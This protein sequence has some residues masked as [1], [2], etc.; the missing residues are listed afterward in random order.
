MKFPRLSRAVTRARDVIARD[1]GFTLIE[2]LAVMVIVGLL[3]A[4]AIPQISKWRE[5]AAITAAEQDA[6]SVVNSFLA[7]SIDHDVDGLDADSITDPEIQAYADLM[8]GG[9]G[10]NEFAEIIGAKM[11]D[12]NSL[13]MLIAGDSEGQNDAGAYI[14]NSKYDFA[15]IYGPGGGLNAA[16]Y[17]YSAGYPVGECD[18]PEVVAWKQSIPTSAQKSGNTIILKGDITDSMANQPTDWTPIC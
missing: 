11:S 5:K 13:T 6:R 17:D 10:G 18:N 3:A 9:T 15:L 14:T 2:V 16:D 7:W 8:Y 4:I 1:G 12:G